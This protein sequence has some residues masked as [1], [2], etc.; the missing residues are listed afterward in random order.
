MWLCE[1]CILCRDEIHSLSQGSCQIYTHIQFQGQT[2]RQSQPTPHDFEPYHYDHK[3][4]NVWQK[5][6]RILWVRWLSKIPLWSKLTSPVKKLLAK[7]A[8]NFI[9]RLD[10]RRCWV[11]NYKTINYFRRGGG[12][13][14]MPTVLKCPKFIY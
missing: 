4:I 3:V 12:V 6:T 14:K 11:I 9:T 5:N 13:V 8:T 1:E 7:V 10:E 2:T